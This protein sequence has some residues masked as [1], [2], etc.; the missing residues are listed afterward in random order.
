MP[1]PITRLVTFVFVYDFGDGSATLPVLCHTTDHRVC[2]GLYPSLTRRRC[3][4]SF[5]LTLHY[6][7]VYCRPL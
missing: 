5:D 7:I 4:G 1:S 3:L 6:R 2:T